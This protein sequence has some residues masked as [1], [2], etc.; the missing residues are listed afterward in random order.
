MSVN[1]SN[2][3]QVGHIYNFGNSNDVNDL[4]Q[5]VSVAAIRLPP[6]EGNVLFHVTRTMLQLLKMKGP[7]GG[8]GHENIHEHNQNF[9]DVCGVFSFKNISLESVRLRLFPIYFISEAT[10][11][12]DDLPRNSITTWDELMVSFFV[13]FFPS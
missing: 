3:S 13:R 10:K 8:L 6:F 11:C 2:G 9:V 4:I 5:L 12:L 1:G 7:Y